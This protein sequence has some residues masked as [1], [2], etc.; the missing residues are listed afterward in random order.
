MT[1]FKKNDKVIVK[2]NEDTNFIVGTFVEYL[3]LDNCNVGIPTVNFG[4]A[5][6]ILNCFGIVIP[7]SEEMIA[8]LSKYT[9][10]Q[11]WELLTLIRDNEEGKQFILLRGIPGSG[12]STRAKE[13]AGEF[14]QVFSTDDYWHINEGGTYQ[15]DINKLGKAHKWN[16][17]RSLAAFGAVPI[18]V[19]DNTNTTLKELRS[20]M[21]HIKRARD[22]GYQVRVEEAGTSWAFDID[23]CFK[24]G[25]HNV[26]K[27]TLEK[28]YNR[29][30]FNADVASILFLFG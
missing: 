26:P 3:G 8:T 1:L 29:Y 9:P 16:Q 27:E 5:V 2:S 24:K 20:Y 17:R 23:E 21:P 7:S 6:G 15:F 25:T 11:Q 30:Y 4:G 12:K 14:G 28:M 19:I 13:L 18:I 10:D 22:M